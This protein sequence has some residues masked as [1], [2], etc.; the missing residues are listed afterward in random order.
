MVGRDRASE[1]YTAASEAE[2]DGLLQTGHGIS[3]YLAVG[4]KLAKL[5]REAPPG[6]GT[7]AQVLGAW[8]ARGHSAS[9]WGLAILWRRSTPQA[10]EVPRP[11]RYA[12]H[13]EVQEELLLGVD[14]MLE[15]SEEGG[16]GRLSFGDRDCRPRVRE[17]L[18]RESGELFF[19]VGEVGG[20]PVKGLLDVA[21][22]VDGEPPEVEQVG[23]AVG[24]DA[25]EG[26]AKTG[27]ALKDVPQENA[28][29]KR[30]TGKAGSPGHLLPRDEAY[31]MLRPLD[32]SP[33]LLEQQLR[34]SGYGQF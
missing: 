15:A 23:Q 28:E 9:S 20:Y 6:R 17:L 18:I 11:D 4:P 16:Q 32:L 29:A 2:L 22:M 14:E 8:L 13:L 5:G 30:R 19:D 34:E 3:R 7:R 10:V 31:E 27:Q 26:G 25:V 33:D 1:C 24:V 12:E 21:A